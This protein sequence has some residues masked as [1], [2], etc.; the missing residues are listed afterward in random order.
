MR[1]ILY[2]LVFLAL[3]VLAGFLFPR[4]VTLERSVYITQPPEAVFPYV[5]DLH[6]FNQ[7][8]PWANLDPKTK[9][10]FSGPSQG[11]GSAMSWRSE[12]PNVGSGSQKIVASE[13]YSLVRTELNFGAQGMAGGEFHLQPQGSGTNVT[14]KFKSDM[15]A[16]PVARWMGL[17]VKRMV[18]QSYEQGLQNLKSVVESGS[19]PAVDEMDSGTDDELPSDEDDTMGAD[20]DDMDS[21]SGMEKPI[22]E[23]EG[24]EPIDEHQ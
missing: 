1:W 7:W 12:N 13:P 18:G 20:P 16:G 11:V 9:Y 10:E 24:E 5:N 2:I 19:V 17:L 3:L 14:W 21:G 6:K 22:L 15:G 23:E 8:S 4:Q